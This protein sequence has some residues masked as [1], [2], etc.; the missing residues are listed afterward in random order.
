MVEEL[1]GC[2]ANGSQ[3]TAVVEV[4]V[5]EDMDRAHMDR[6]QHN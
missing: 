1:C 2:H 4:V 5:A 3:V 6:Q